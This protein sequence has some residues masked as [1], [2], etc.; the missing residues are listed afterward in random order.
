MGSVTC[1]RPPN[2]LIFASDKEVYLKCRALFESVLEQDW[3]TYERYIYSRNR[4]GFKFTSL[5]VMHFIISMNWHF[6]RVKHGS[7]IQPC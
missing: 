3:Y 2:I 6:G 7:A 4:F 5:I 1:M